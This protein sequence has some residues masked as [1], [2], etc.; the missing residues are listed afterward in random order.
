MTVEKHSPAYDSLYANFKA[1]NKTYPMFNGSA[2]RSVYDTKYVAEHGD[3]SLVI[4]R[5]GFDFSH[6]WTDTNVTDYFPLEIWNGDQSKL[7]ELT[8]ESWDWILYNRNVSNV[9]GAMP[10]NA[11]IWPISAHI[12]SAFS[13]TKEAKS[14]LQL[15]L[16]YMLVVIACNIVK[17]SIMIWTLVVDRSTYI[18]TLGDGVVSFLQRFDPITRSNC[19]L[20]RDEMLYKIGYMPYHQLEGEDLDTHMLRVEGMWLPQRR[21]YFALMGKDRQIFYALL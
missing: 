21:R 15:S 13:Q 4:D 8:K 19:M 5:F 11:T 3:L 18:V 2:W 14:R 12:D 9:T 10:S 7:Q 6:N 16:M 1:D 20:G 17:L